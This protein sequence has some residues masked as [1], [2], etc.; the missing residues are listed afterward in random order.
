[1][2]FIKSS[3]S[4]KDQSWEFKN[5]KFLQEIAG[6]WSPPS[7]PKVGPLSSHVRLKNLKFP[8][9]KN[10]RPYCQGMYEPPSSTLQF[11]KNTKVRILL[12][13]CFDLMHDARRK[14]AS[15]LG[16]AVGHDGSKP[17]PTVGGVG[18]ALRGCG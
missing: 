16:V 9:R 14:T 7:F 15:F 1:M 4:R 12:N 17:R 8:P 18:P 6:L 11:P 2:G 13:G 10:R 5:A 3:F